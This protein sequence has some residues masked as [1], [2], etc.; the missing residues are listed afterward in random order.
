MFEFRQETTRRWLRRRWSHPSLRRTQR[1]LR[2]LRRRKQE[3][4][5]CTHL[6]LDSPRVPM[7]TPTSRRRVR[8]RSRYGTHYPL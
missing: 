5:H 4:V 7:L 2:R 1:S 6:V 3:Q 8:V